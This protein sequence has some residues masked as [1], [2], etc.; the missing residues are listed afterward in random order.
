MRR[1]ADRRRPTRVFSYPMFRD[2]EARAGAVRG[3][4]RAPHLRREPVR[5]ARH[6]ARTLG[7]TFR[8]AISPCSAFSRR[9]ADCSARKTIAVDRQADAVVLSHALLAEAQFAADTAVLGRTL[10]VNRCCADDRRRGATQVQRHDCGHAGSVF[11]PI[12]FQLSAMRRPRYPESRQSRRS[13]ASISSRA[14]SRASRARRLARR[15]RTR[16]SIEDS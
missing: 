5:P 1:D 12:T 7:C 8:E 3:T 11:V 10:I 6:A 4:G 15:H 9:S 2:L 13:L 14:S 16:C